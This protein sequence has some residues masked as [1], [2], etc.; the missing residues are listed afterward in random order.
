MKPPVICAL[1]VAAALLGAGLAVTP[2]VADGCNVEVR[3]ICGSAGSEDFQMAG[4]DS[5]EGSATAVKPATNSGP[6]I[7]RQTRYAPTCTGNSAYDPGVLCSAAVETCPVEGE[8]RFWVWSRTFDEDLND[9]TTWTLVDT[10]C[11]AA[12]DPAI[13]PA[14]A[15]PMTVQREFTSVVVLRGEAEVSPEPDTL[16]NIPTVFTTSA[17]ASYDIPLT[18]LGQDVVITATAQRYTWHFGD[19]ETG[20]STAPGG[21]IEH[22]YAEA[23]T[24]GAYVVIEWSGT[25][26]VNG[27]ASQPITGTATTTGVP[28]VVEV[29]QARAE[30]VRD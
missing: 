8:F 9:W 28:T 1:A 13:D 15:V 30:L 2:A 20:T 17:P 27:G 23:E 4:A 18:L 11:L 26:R 6:T 25:F 24:V 14:V 21:R 19:G 16:V 10:V 29:K 3:G 7:R 12:D 5:S 22:E